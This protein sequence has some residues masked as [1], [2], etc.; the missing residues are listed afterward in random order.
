MEG[1]RIRIVKVAIEKT[2]YWPIGGGSQKAMW[3]WICVMPGCQRGARKLPV[4]ST[5][6][7]IKQHIDRRHSPWDFIE[8]QTYAIWKAEEIEK[9][10]EALENQKGPIPHKV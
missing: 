3:K 9:Q 7:R 10:V 6:D 4:Y 5:W 2:L 1:K 8:V